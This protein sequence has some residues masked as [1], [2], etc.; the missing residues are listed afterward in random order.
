MAIDVGDRVSIIGG[1]DFEP[2]WLAGGVSVA[3]TVLKWIPGQNETPACVLRLDEPLTAEGDV[4]GK[5]AV[6]TGSH[7]VLELRATNFGK[8]PGLF[9]LSCV[10]SSRRTRPGRSER[11]QH[12]SNRMQ[13]T[14]ATSAHKCHSCALAGGGCTRRLRVGIVGRCLSGMIVDRGTCY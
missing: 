2:A 13:R 12:G 6:L 10:L 7:V 14:S 8:T 1:Y 11:S 4:R 5:R 9:T 3:G